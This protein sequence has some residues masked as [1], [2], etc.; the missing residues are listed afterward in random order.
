MSAQTL[1]RCRPKRRQNIGGHG[2]NF[3]KSIPELK[4]GGAQKV[5]SIQ[6]TSKILILGFLFRFAPFLTIILGFSPTL[7]MLWPS[8][9]DAKLHPCRRA[10]VK[11]SERHRHCV[12]IS[13]VNRKPKFWLSDK[14]PKPTWFLVFQLKFSWYFVGFKILTNFRCRDN[15]S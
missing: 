15:S 11:S 3:S 9:R 7:E 10:V 14:K 2:C 1:A 4:I 13:D 6:G 12:A 8:Q 5:K